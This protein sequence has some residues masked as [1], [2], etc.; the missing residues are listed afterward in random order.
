[1]D[2]TGVVEQFVLCVLEGTSNLVPA[3]IKR[4]RGT[5]LTVYSEYEV[6]PRTPIYLLP[7]EPSETPS[8]DEVLA[9][10]ETIQGVIILVERDGSFL[11]RTRMKW[12]PDAARLAAAGISIPTGRSSTKAA[13]SD[14]TETAVQKEATGSATVSWQRIGGVQLI[15]LAGVIDV[16]GAALLDRVARRA[17][18]S[19]RAI[20]LDASDVD[21]LP[22]F[23]LGVIIALAR[24]MQK[25]NT[26]VA[27]AAMPPDVQ[28]V[29]EISRLHRLVSTHDTVDDAMAELSGA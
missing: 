17:A 29:V 18:Q 24:D 10:E 15:G 2:S 27:L 11:V 13:A 8:K 4:R 14:E 28:R 22:S 5:E 21:H 6:P 1:M 20:V 9:N 26:P 7:C 12:D 23:G 25:R 16:G 3:T 19:C